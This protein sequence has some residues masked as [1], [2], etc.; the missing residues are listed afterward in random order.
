MLEPT[1]LWGFSFDP[2]SFSLLNL[3]PALVPNC[4]AMGTGYVYAGVAGCK[5]MGQYPIGL[6][7]FP[8]VEL[9][10]VTVP[11]FYGAHGIVL[12]YSRKL[13]AG[14]LGSITP[15]HMPFPKVWKVRDRRVP[16]HFQKSS[17]SR[18]VNPAGTAARGQ[19]TGICD[20]VEPPAGHG[21]GPC[22]QYLKF[23]IGYGMVQSG[24][25]R[26]TGLGSGS[27]G[28]SCTEHKG[29]E[30]GKKGNSF[31]MDGFNPLQSTKSH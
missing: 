31:H 29:H 30:N 5:D 7:P 12:G 27:R 4:A 15:S 8:D 17:R 25:F 23:P 21:L 20:A 6:L 10:G 24:H 19:K 3:K 16:H 2:K 28:A 9:H 22:G 13:D 14:A 26:W 11:F 18:Y 1:G